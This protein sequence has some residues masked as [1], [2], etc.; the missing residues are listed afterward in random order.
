MNTNARTM[1]AGSLA[2]A[3]TACI[4]DP[5]TPGTRDEQL[6]VIL[7]G[8]VKNLD[9]RFTVDSTSM[10]VSRLVFSNLVT[11]DNPTVEPAL[12][13]AERIEADPSSLD[14]DGRPSRYIVHLRRGI[15]WHDGVE[16]TARDVVYTYRSILDPALGSPYRGGFGRKLKDVRPVP[17]DPYA[18]V[19]ELVVPY[20]TFR[21]D[22]VMGIVPAHVLDDRAHAD[23]PPGRF[24]PDGYVGTGPF[25]LHSRLG[26]RRTVLERNEA[27]HGGAPAYRYLVFR[28][29]DD[30]GTRLLALVGGSGDL[31]MNGLSPVLL[32]VVADEPHL[33][34]E[35]APAL[36]W[37]YLA[38]NLRDPVVGDPRVRRALDLAL[39]RPEV[40]R[41]KLKGHAGPSVGMMAPV[42]WAHAG[43][44]TPT[45]PDPAAAEALLD[46]A[47]YTRDPETGRRLSVGLKISN[48][49]FRRSV[50]RTV[51][52]QLARVG[53]RVELVSFEHGT[54]LSD[55]RKGNF[56]MTL[57]Q[58]P[59]PSEPDMLRWMF[60]S[61]STP[62][63]EPAATGR[64]E[65]RL[66]RRFFVPGL[67]RLLTGDDPA[68]VR[69][70]GDEL[71]RGAV[72][73]VQRAWG[74]DPPRDR[75]NRTY[76]TNP[77]FDC[78]IMRGWAEPDR[79]KRRPLYVEAQHILAEERPV[80]PLW[81][82]N[83]VIVRHRR[84]RGFTIL[85]NGRWTPLA[86]VTLSGG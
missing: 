44:L 70:A 30:E 22:L 54:F 81:H 73:W 4:S 36:S 61:L 34:V 3:L 40:I 27:Y 5:P 86:D 69:W 74:H 33:V 47:G 1:L 7:D 6:V 60:F 29:I 51:T 49:R 77:R 78:L 68:C 11:V 28:T 15:R 31:L 12:D 64:E 25:R 72:R 21:T 57:L 20:A 75:S 83:N 80:L 45:A 42:S 10:K 79:A 55:I 8:A 46:A 84:V 41:R 37:T 43:D 63:V 67:D 9:P 24:P 38:F 50:A 18:V 65:A 14:A 53:V 66:D 58:L 16:L 62:G 76:Y 2:L 35:S 32:D 48:N 59:E 85:P 19:F 82:E 56:Q 17:D 52:D 13:L 23:T 39:D 26:D 71:V